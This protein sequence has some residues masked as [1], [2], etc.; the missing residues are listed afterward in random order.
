MQTGSHFNTDGY[1]ETASMWMELAEREK[2]KYRTPRLPQH[3][4]EKRG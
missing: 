4:G 3:V 2:K 1:R